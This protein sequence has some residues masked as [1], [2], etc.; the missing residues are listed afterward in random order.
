ML[1][2]PTIEMADRYVPGSDIKGALSI[3]LTY[4]GPA[5]YPYTAICYVETTWKDGSHTRGT[6]AMVGPNDVLTAGQM[7]WDAEHGGSAVSVTVIP[8]Y[9]NGAASFGTYQG[10]LFSYYPI[11]Q[12]GDDSLLTGRR[13][14]TSASSDFRPRSVIG[15]VRLASKQIPTQA[16]S[17]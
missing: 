9:N 5:D 3:A 6:G 10:A 7:L 12:D 4:R 14:G 17:R 2:D 16:S 13:N 11:D 1:I 15:P 8:G